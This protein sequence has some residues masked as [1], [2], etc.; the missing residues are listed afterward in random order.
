[1]N[2]TGLD[3]FDRTIHP[4]NTW[5]DEMMKTLPHDKKLAWHAL[6]TVLRSRS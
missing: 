4:T 6:G 5:L 3:V 2:T 1:M